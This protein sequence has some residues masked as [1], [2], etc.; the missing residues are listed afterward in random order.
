LGLF[1]GPL[2]KGI[3]FYAAITGHMPDVVYKI[4]NTSILVHLANEIPDI[5]SLGR[6]LISFTF[7]KFKYMYKPFISTCHITVKPNE[8]RMYIT[9]Q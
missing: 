2:L 8:G 6:S 9:K 3:Y 5:V 1:H 4:Y 7:R